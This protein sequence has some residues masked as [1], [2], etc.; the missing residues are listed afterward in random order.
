MGPT[1]IRADPVAVFPPIQ[2]RA[3]LASDP[4]PEASRQEVYETGGGSQ[5]LRE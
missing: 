5:V 1:L 4:A 3:T 2:V